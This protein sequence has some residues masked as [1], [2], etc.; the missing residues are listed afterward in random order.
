MILNQRRNVTA[1]NAALGRTDGMVWFTDQAG[2]S[3]NHVL[4]GQT[5]E[6]ITVP[7]QRAD[8]CIEEIGHVPQ[9]VKLDVEGHEYD[10][11]EGF[12]Q[13]LGSVGVVMIEMN[14]LS[15]DRG[16]GRQAVHTTLRRAGLDGPWQCDFDRHT[17]RIQDGRSREDSLYVSAQYQRVLSTQGWAIE[18]IR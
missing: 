10:V 12:G 4:S 11:L 15:D 6:A 9:F 7:A 13:Y 16:P 5:R 18:A 3:I 1:W 17:L 8:R 14:G 2:S